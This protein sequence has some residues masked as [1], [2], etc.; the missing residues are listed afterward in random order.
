MTEMTIANAVS[1]QH[2]HRA[3]QVPNSNFN[4]NFEFSFNGKCTFPIVNYMVAPFILLATYDFPPYSVLL[5]SAEDH[6]SI[7]R[8]F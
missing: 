2:L 8:Q 4:A 6:S 3:R 1:V 7:T 5:L